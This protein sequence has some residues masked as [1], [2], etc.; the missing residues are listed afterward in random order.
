LSIIRSSVSLLL[1][2]ISLWRAQPLKEQA[3]LGNAAPS[4]GA[5]YPHNAADCYHPASH[6]LRRRWSETQQRPQVRCAHIGSLYRVLTI[7]MHAA[8]QQLRLT[9]AS[10]KAY[11]KSS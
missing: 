6:L 1:K 9:A 8:C 4:A 5:A 7:F 11:R 10:R 3:H 2:E